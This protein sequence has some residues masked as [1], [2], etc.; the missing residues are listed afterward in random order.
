MPPEVREFL[1]HEKKR[2]LQE[3]PLEKT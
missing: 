2:L 1:R 3:L